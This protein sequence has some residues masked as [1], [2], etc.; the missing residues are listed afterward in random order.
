MQCRK[1]RRPGFNSRVRK[2]PWRRAWQ[3]TQVFLPGESYG[4]RSPVGY[5]PQDHK[6]LD[7]TEA[8]EHA[9]MHMELRN[10]GWLGAKESNPNLLL[11][12]VVASM[13][14]WPGAGQWH[15]GPLSLCEDWARSAWPLTLLYIQDKV[16]EG[17]TWVL[18][19]PPAQ[20]GSHCCLFGQLNKMLAS[21]FTAH[22]SPWKKGAFPPKA[23]FDYYSSCFYYIAC[24]TQI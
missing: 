22:K 5:T 23:L 8:T 7:M 19:S 21:E 12:G 20:K 13:K 10:G 4:Q 2:L 9:C 17:I 1:H 6:E 16:L 18:G 3:P 11:P 14:H 24:I 15:C